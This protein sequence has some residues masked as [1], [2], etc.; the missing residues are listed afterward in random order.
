MEQHSGVEARL[1][2]QWSGTGLSYT[3]KVVYSTLLGLFNKCLGT[4]DA[5]WGIFPGAYGCYMAVLLDTLAGKCGISPLS[6]SGE[7]FYG[8]SCSADM[9]TLTTCADI[10]CV[11]LSDI[12]SDYMGRYVSLLDMFTLT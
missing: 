2:L 7:P 1:S 3:L 12:F 8:W 5:N 10:L 9:A 6:L 11:S 4:L